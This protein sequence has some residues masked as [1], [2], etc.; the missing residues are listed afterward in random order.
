M[1]FVNWLSITLENLLFHF[2]T[3]SFNKNPSVFLDALIA[4]TKNNP[5]NLFYSAHC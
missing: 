3:T 1:I 2:E 4:N 5:S